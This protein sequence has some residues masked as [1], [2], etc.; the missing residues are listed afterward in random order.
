MSYGRE[1]AISS[2]NAVEGALNQFST[3]V[4]GHGCIYKVNMGYTVI[5][6]KFDTLLFGQ[7]HQLEIQT[8]ARYRVDKLAIIAIRLEGKRSVNG[9]HHAAMHRYGYSLYVAGGPNLPER[10]KSAIAQR[11]IYRPANICSFQPHIGSAF[12]D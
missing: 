2:D 3:N 7:I 4:A 11:E 8:A 5:E 12:E 10:F 9:V 6:I 1:R